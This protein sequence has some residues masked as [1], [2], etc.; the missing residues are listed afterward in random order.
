M[1]LDKKQTPHTE[2]YTLEFEEVNELA[3]LEH[4]YKREDISISILG[5]LVEATEAIP[6]L[7]E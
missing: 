5:D 2:W 1:D 7:Y 4:P 3:R 6:S